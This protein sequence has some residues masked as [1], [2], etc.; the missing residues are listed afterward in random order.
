MNG[1]NLMN[2]MNPIV[3]QSTY[4]EADI[5]RISNDFIQMM[6]TIRKEATHYGDVINECDK[7]FSDV[8]HYC[9]LQQPKNH[10]SKTTVTKLLHDISC[11]RRKA[12]DLQYLSEALISIDNKAYD[13]IAKAV[14]QVNK[15][16]EKT[17][18]GDR[19]YQPR[20]LTDLFK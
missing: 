20:V 15:R 18:S 1:I 2:Q 19:H 14:N 12:K 6:R 10:K 8:Y 17:F 7:A 4:T 16:H 5:N 11:V 9:E 13:E 3:L